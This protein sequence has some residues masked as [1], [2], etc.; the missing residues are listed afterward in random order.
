[1]ATF[2]ARLPMEMASEIAVAQPGGPPV[3]A[4][5]R[6]GSD[7]AR[8]GFV[9]LDRFDMTFIRKLSGR[10]FESARTNHANRRCGTVFY[11]LKRGVPNVYGPL[12]CGP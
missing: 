2:P 5:I 12:S 3:V 7:M 10:R 8:G 9:W 1:M 6:E 11:A 4:R